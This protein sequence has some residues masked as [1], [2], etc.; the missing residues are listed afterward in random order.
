MNSRVRSRSG[1]LLAGIQ[2]VLILSTAAMFWFDRQISPRA[3]VPTEPVDPNLPI[4]GRYITLNMVVPL[5]SKRLKKSDG[6]LLN[7][8]QKVHLVAVGDRLIADIDDLAKS[9]LIDG[10]VR[11]SGDDWVVRPDHELAFFIPPDVQD[12]SIQPDGRTLWVEVTVPRSGAPRPIQLGLDVNGL[13]QPLLL[14]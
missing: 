2:A 4:R 1:L 9:N 8:R 6:D 7:T 11:R 3:W 5:R 14:R 10:S 12:P 13:I